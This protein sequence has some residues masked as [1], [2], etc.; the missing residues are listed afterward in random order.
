MEKKLMFRNELSFLSNFYPVK[1]RVGN[2]EFPTLEHAFQAAK[3]KDMSLRLK[4]ACLKTPAD[5]KRHGRSLVI[6]S[7]WD[8]IKVKSME[9]LLR[10]KFEK[11]GELASRLTATGNSPLVEWNYWGDKFWGKDM[12]SGEGLNVLGELLMKIRKELREV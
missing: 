7:D 8:E 6:R 3:T 2:M 9:W 5:A 12:K 4:I 11:G 1:I 10:R